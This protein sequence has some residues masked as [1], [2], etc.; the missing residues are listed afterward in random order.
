[1]RLLVMN[2]RW[3]MK[4]F[5]F[6]RMDS[7]DVLVFILLQNAAAIKKNH[8]EW[9]IEPNIYIC[10]KVI[11]QCFY[12]QWH[13]RKICTVGRQKT[14]LYSEIMCNELLR[15]KDHFTC[16]VQIYRQSWCCQVFFSLFSLQPLIIKFSVD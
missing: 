16:E 3:L 10:W 8:Q 5:P 12:T 7:F 1:M 4:W 2:I 11:E 9:K 6:Y 14:D 15:S 13:T